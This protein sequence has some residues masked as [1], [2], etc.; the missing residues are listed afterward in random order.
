VFVA[1]RE[2]TDY[3]EP[4]HR[5]ETL[6]GSL[7]FL[8]KGR[9]RITRGDKEM[10]LIAPTVYWHIKGD[11]F[12]Y[13]S[14]KGG[15]RNQIWANFTGPRAERLVR[16][17]AEEMPEQRAAMRKPEECHALFREMLEL[18]NQRNPENHFRMA[19]LLE[20]LA[21]LTLESGRFCPAESESSAKLKTLA[22]EIRT[23]PAED[24]DFQAEARR[25]G[26]S[27]SGLRSRFRQ[28]AGMAPHEYL[29]RCRVSHASELLARPGMAVKRAA[30]LCGFGEISSFS[31]LFK[32]KTGV[33]PRGFIQSL[34]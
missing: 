20:R 32:L 16:G 33:S 21:G 24:W 5:S 10:T 19:V 6:Y 1:V 34:K 8:W 31:R 13:K 2:V 30:E 28:S 23:R 11:K 3:P 18:F 9:M 29:L 12:Q 15:L 27:Y 26:M 7:E 14:V 4:G 25:L 22:E 17:L